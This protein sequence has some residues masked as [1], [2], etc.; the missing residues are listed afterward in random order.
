M[1]IISD[2]EMGVIVKRKIVLVPLSTL[3]SRPDNFL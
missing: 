3:N 2:K 1:V